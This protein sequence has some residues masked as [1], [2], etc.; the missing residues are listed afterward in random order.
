MNH[1]LG[2][3]EARDFI[4]MGVMMWALL[5]ISTSMQQRVDLRRLERKLDA[6]LEHGGIAMPSRLSPEVQRMAADPRQK[7]AA[8]KMHREQNPG[9]GLAEAKTEIEDFI[10]KAG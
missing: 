8:I 3:L 10:A 6:L 5:L 2:I 9:L 4:I 1:L 7:I